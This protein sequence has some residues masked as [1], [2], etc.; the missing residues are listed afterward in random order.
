MWVKSLSPVP[1]DLTSSYLH[2]Y[3]LMY[4]YKIK[5]IFKNLNPKFF[6]FSSD[7]GASLGLYMLL[8]VS[9]LSYTLAVKTVS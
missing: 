1:K 6:I 5:Y 9:P 2:V 7:L 4:I 3:I 8:T